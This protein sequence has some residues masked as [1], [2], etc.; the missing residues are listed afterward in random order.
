LEATITLEFDDEEV[1]K[2]VADAVS[3]DNYKTPANLTIKTTQAKTTVTT[4]IQTQEKLL[5]FIATI[6][7]LLFSITIAEKTL[8]TIQQT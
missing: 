6:D 7:D 5:T 8:Q 3:P 2:A 1:A 4:N